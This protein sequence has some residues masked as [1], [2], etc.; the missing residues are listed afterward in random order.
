MKRES[1][2]KGKVVIVTGAAAGIGRVTALGFAAEGAK[3]AAWDVIEK[4]TVALVSS[5]QES[6]G[7]GMFQRGDVTNAA[8]VESA[9]AEIVAE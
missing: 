3:V 8:E 4:D 5:L 6:G 7:D 2:L 1:G 9:V